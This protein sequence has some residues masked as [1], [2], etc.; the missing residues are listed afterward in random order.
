[1]LKSDGAFYCSFKYG[2]DEVERDQRTFT[3]LN[4]FLLSQVLQGTSLTVQSTWVTSD[5][6]PS[7]QQEQWLNAILI[8]S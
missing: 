3:N 7:R 5:L 2:D 6:R 4:E 8:K 1:M